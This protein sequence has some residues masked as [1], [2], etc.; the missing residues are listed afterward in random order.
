MVM[1]VKCKPA[2]SIKA[3]SQV[4]HSHIRSPQTSCDSDS[5]GWASFQHS[6][7]HLWHLRGTSVSRAPSQQH[8]PHLCRTTPALS[9]LWQRLGKV[10]SCGQHHSASGQAQAASTRAPP[11]QAALWDTPACSLAWGCHQLLLGGNTSAFQASLSP[12]CQPHSPTPPLPFATQGCGMLFKLNPYCFI[13]GEVFRG[14]AQ[15]PSHSCTLKIAQLIRVGREG[16]ASPGTAHCCPTA[17]Q[18][19]SQ[20]LRTH[21]DTLGIKAVLLS[22]HSR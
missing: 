2:F 8:V 11:C 14:F 18:R 3:P 1:L 10:L 9:S 20:G 5:C 19:G 16:R 12:S 6:K 4:K 7:G 13:A 15:A 22:T 21:W 17:S